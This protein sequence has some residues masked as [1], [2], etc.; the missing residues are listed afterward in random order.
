MSEPSPYDAIARLY[1]PWSRSVTEDVQFYVERGARR[2]RRRS[3]SSASA[4]AGSRSRSRARGVRVIGVDSSRGMLARLPRGG[5]RAPASPSCST[6]AHGDLREPPVDRARAARDLS[7]SARSS[8]STPTPERLQRARAPPASCSSRAA[9]SSSTSSRPRRTTSRRRTAAGSSASRASSSAP[10]GTRTRA[11]SR[12]PCA[13]PTSETTM[14]ARVA[15]RR[16]SG[17]TLLERAASRSWPATAGS[18]GGP[19][20][21]GEDAIWVA[22]TPDRIESSRDL[23]RHHR[24]RS[25]S[26]SCS[27]SS[28]S[29]CTTGSSGCGT[30]RE[31]AWAQVDVQLRRRYD[32]IPNLV[33][34]VKGYAAHE[35]ET[36]EEVTAA[37]TAA[38]QAQGRAGAGAGGERADR[39]RSA[40]SSPSPR[41]IRSCARPR[42]SSSCR[43]SWRTPSR[44][45]QI[46]RQVY[47]DTVLTYDNAIQTVPTSIIAGMFHFEPRDVLRDRRRRLPARHRRSVRYRRLRQRRRVR[48][49][50]RRARRGLVAASRR[51]RA[52]RR[53]GAEVV[54]APAAHVNVRVAPTEPSWSPRTSPSPSTAPSPARTATSRPERARRSTTS[55]WPRAARATRPAASPSW[56]AIGPPGTFGTSAPRTRCASSGTST[57]RRRA[58]HLHGRVPHQR[59]RRRLRRRRRRQPEGLGR[60]VDRRRSPAP[61]RRRSTLPGDASGRRATASGAIRAGCTARRAQPT[62]SDAAR[63]RRS[64]APVRRA[65][66]RLPPRAA[67]LDR[68]AR[69]SCTATASQRSSRDRGRRERRSRAT[70]SSIDDAKHHSGARCLILL[71]ARAR[72]GAARVRRSSTSSSAASRATAYDREYEQEPP[73]DPAPA[74]VPPLLRAEA[75]AS[76]RPSSPRRSST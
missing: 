72:P 17:A 18:T 20:A 9:A 75:R 39:R 54:H 59:P 22:R 50:P 66:R 10:T 16:S 36:F 28:S 52:R 6:C 70:R 44:R 29:R 48:R 27:R 67:H 21:G 42:T 32:L 38:Q 62:R 51:C 37:R 45:S 11:R 47:N 31:N 68:A 26:S 63:A 46:S 15:L 60:P 65:A 24:R 3:S 57:R 33:E 5:A 61:R 53:A 7:R 35:R 71:A 40:G 25:C 69:R 41:P 49:R 58:A 64:R 12:S 74:L 14:A 8:T 76:A 1:D 73:T 56:A 43:S 2:G 30:A 23:R 4:P 34:T 19:Y 13:A 55:A